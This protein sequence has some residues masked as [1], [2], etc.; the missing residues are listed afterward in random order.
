[1]KLLYKA[2]I[3]YHRLFRNYHNKKASLRSISRTKNHDHKVSYYE[4]KI[5]GTD[6][7]C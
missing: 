2:M 1:M 6:Y 4:E 5:R 3:L 7:G